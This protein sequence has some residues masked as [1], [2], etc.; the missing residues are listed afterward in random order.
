MKN[1]LTGTKRLAK[2]LVLGTILIV[3]AF[4]YK[5]F[6]DKENTDGLLGTNEARAD[7]EGGPGPGAPGGD[8]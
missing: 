1:F 4:V 8:S 3:V 6:T 7:D 5:V 2:I